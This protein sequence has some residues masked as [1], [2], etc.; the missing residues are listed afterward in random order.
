MKL[1]ADNMGRVTCAEL[2]QPNGVFDA[3]KQPDG[4]IRV[5]ELVDVP[6]VKLVRTKE[7]FLL[8]PGKPDRKLIIRAV[9]ADR[10][11]R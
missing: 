1:I 6:V 5:V 9:R 10:D 3:T 8:L 2:F 7:G 4:S 11:A